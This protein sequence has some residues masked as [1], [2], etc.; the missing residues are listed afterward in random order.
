MQEH[1][2]ATQPSPAG[3]SDL[4]AELSALDPLAA[5]TADLTEQVDH[6]SGIPPETTS[7]GGPCA[8]GSER[9]CSGTC[10]AT[11]F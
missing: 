3:D 4:L 5:P 10:L 2:D 6:L 1:G 7:L 9:F 8:D 11:V